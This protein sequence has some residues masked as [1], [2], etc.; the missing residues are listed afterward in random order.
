MSDTERFFATETTTINTNTSDI[1]A[2]WVDING[3]PRWDDGLE[4]TRFS[5]IFREG[6]SFELTPRGGEALTVTLRSV[7]QGEEFSDEAVL[8]FGKIRNAHR[9]RQV[10]GKVELTHEVEAVINKAEAGFFSNE[11]WPHMRDGLAGA[12]ANIQEIAES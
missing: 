4:S 5:G 2:I 1:W 12:L 6:G 8:P 10:D 9:M 3:W 11:I 7:T